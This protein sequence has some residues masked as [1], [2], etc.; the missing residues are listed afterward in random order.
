VININSYA[1]ALEV[2][3]LHEFALTVVVKTFHKTTKKQLN[4]IENQQ[5]KV[6]WAH[7]II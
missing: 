1:I 6:F 2:Y 5:S 4:G 7:N 3:I